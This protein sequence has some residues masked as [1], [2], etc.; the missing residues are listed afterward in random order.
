MNNLDQQY[1][2]LLEDI[3]ENGVDKQTRNGGTRSVFG[4]TIRHD[5]SEGFPLLTTK[6]MH[7]KGIVGELL[8]FL[9]GSTDI[10][11]LWKNNIKIWDGD[12]YKYYKSRV[13]S[14]YTL[15]EIKSKLKSGNH[16]FS[17]DM[18]NMG[19]IYGK[20]WRRWGGSY[21]FKG[22]QLYS[23]TSVDQIKNVIELLETDPDSRRIIVNAWNIGEIKASLLP[24]CH[25]LFQFWTRELADE[26]RYNLLEQKLIN[27]E[28]LPKLNDVLNDPQTKEEF[29]FLLEVERIPERAIS[30]LWNQRSVDTP[31][32]LP[33]NIASYGLMLELVAKQV[34]MIPDQLIGNLGDV[35]IYHNQFDGVEEQI[36]RFNDYNLPSVGISGEYNLKYI[37]K[38]P[39]L[40][41]I[42]LVNYESDNR[43]NFPLSN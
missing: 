4:R 33:F 38:L 39:N 10:R 12:W 3:M 8:W 7:F 28:S 27:K 5:M 15:E 34:G 40:S 42:R 1:I 6:K 19:A 20:Q 22:H 14:P 37:D 30:L 29:Y 24:P 35:H 9:S 36:S 11:D 18:F 43:I 13:S 21:S 16:S 2:E 26:E 41:Q 32:G 23:D 25:Y 17:N 31:L